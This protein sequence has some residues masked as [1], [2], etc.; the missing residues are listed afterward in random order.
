MQIHL[1]LYYN[2]GSLLYLQ[3]RRRNVYAC[4]LW[5]SSSFCPGIVFGTSNKAWNLDY[6]VLML[7]EIPTFRSLLNVIISLRPAAIVV[8]VCIVKDEYISNSK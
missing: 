6:E 5:E 4:E 2:F 1:A 3:R 7:R 8:S